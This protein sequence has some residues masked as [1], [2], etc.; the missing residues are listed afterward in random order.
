[1]SDNKARWIESYRKFRDPIHY[2]QTHPVTTS[3]WPRK[4]WHYMDCSSS[5][6]ALRIFTFME[7][8]DARGGRA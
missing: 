5:P 3:A 2:R 4:W 7:W 1:V 8:Y 6:L